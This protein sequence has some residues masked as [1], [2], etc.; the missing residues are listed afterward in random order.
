MASS[1]KPIHID[2]V[3]KVETEINY[4]NE[5]LALDSN[6]T[7]AFVFSGLHFNEGQKHKLVCD[8][9]D[10]SQEEAYKGSLVI[11]AVEDYDDKK[12]LQSDSIG[13]SG[14]RS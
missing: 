6:K 2:E 11:N 1:G 4:R 3:V 7:G 13:T 5:N 8:I 12:Q 10:V 9:T 14:K